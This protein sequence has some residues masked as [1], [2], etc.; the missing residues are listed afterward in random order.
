MANGRVTKKTPVKKKTAI[1]EEALIDETMLNSE[2]VFGG[3]EDLAPDFTGHNS[4]F[5]S[6]LGMGDYGF[7]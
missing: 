1:K 3:Q 6:D 2:E 4:G 5:E 7:N